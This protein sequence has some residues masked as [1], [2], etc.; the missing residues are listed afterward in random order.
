[1][2]EQAIKVRPA[3]DTCD[4]TVLVDAWASWDMTSQ[5]WELHTTFDMGFCETCDGESKYTFK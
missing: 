5:K 2:A 1:M 3:C 4:S